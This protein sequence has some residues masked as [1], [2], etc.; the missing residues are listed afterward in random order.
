[1]R[2][3]S[4]YSAISPSAYLVRG[5]KNPRRPSPL[6]RGTTWTCRCGT[7]WLTVLFIATNEPVEPSAVRT[8]AAIRRAAANTGSSSASGRS[9]SV[10]TCSRGTT[11]TW[12]LKTGRRSRNA[13][14]VSVSRTTSAGSS[15]RTTA[16]NSQPSP[17]TVSV[18]HDGCRRD[19]V[20]QRL[21]HPDGATG[22]QRGPG[23]G[24]DQPV[25][26]LVVQE[27][28]RAVA[29]GCGRGGLRWQEQGVDAT[30][31]RGTP[32]LLETEH[33]CAA[34]ELLVEPV[35]QRLVLLLQALLQQRPRSPA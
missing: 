7:D 20:R 11:R 28:H 14:T 16:Q 35:Q 9:V 32:G 8:V 2:R 25:A 21:D 26:G 27:N 1:A 23:C 3:R 24:G 6:V 19:G 4:A 29:V 33:P 31:P 30:L 17:A 12:P 18:P 10:S 13:M 5:Q 15:P 22:P 34:G